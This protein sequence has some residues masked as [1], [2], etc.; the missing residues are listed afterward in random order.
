MHCTENFGRLHYKCMTAV[1]TWND[2]CCILGSDLLVNVWDVT[3]HG[4]NGCTRG[5]RWYRTRYEGLHTLYE[6][7]QDTVWMAAHIVWDGTGHGMN[8][9]MYYSTLGPFCVH[10][11]WYVLWGGPSVLVYCVA[12]NVRFLLSIAY[13]WHWECSVTWDATLSFWQKVCVL[14]ERQVFRF[15]VRKNIACCCKLMG[16]MI[17]V[18]LIGHHALT[19]VSFNGTLWFNSR[20][21]AVCLILVI[22][23]V[24]MSAEMWIVLGKQDDWGI[25]VSS[26]HPLRVH[27]ILSCCT[28]CIIDILQ[29]VCLMWMQLHQF[30]CIARLWG[31]PTHLLIKLYHS[32]LTLVS[33]LT[34]ASSGLSYV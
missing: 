30:C 31:W 10:C 7:I 14:T 5:L 16:S 26:I 8:G 21:V 15:G 9:H 19:L 25:D 23:G 13:Q 1:I 29:Y 33:S 20:F 6:M 17:I 27:K 22:L 28:S 34:T 18:A 4:M 3:G 11:N 12:V 32:F 2:C 24:C